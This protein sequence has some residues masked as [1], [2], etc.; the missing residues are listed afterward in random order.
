MDQ[1]Q[2]KAGVTLHFLCRC[3]I[4]H[5]QKKHPVRRSHYMWHLRYWLQLGARGWTGCPIGALGSLFG[6]VLKHCH[7]HCYSQVP[8]MIHTAVALGR[9]KNYLL[10]HFFL[11]SVL[12]SFLFVIKYSYT[13]TSADAQSYL[14]IYSAFYSSALRNPDQGNGN[15]GKEASYASDQS[16]FSWSRCF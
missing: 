6:M 11:S 15:Y 4:G 16:H 7:L 9:M 13:H 2:T 5:L 3:N 12:F 14:L 8:D 10:C 1:N